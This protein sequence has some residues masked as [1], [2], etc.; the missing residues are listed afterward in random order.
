MEKRWN[1]ESRAYEHYATG[2]FIDG[3]DYTL[4]AAM[5]K[6]HQRGG[7]GLCSDSRARILIGKMIEDGLQYDKHHLWL[8]AME[9]GIA[10][11]NAVR[12]AEMTGKVTGGQT[13]KILWANVPANFKPGLQA[14]ITYN[15][16][17]PTYDRGAHNTCPAKQTGGVSNFREFHLTITKEGRAVTAQKDGEIF[18]YYSTTHAAATYNYQ[19]V[20]FPFRLTSNGE[21]YEVAMTGGKRDKLITLP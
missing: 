11:A 2:P 17:N 21:S 3:V 14:I 18:L 16:Y 6:W 19:L 4:K 7:A 5:E 1:P 20:V 12:V 9:A 10:A 15:G 13:G 8:N